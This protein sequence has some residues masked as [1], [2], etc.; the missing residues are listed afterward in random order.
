MTGAARLEASRSGLEASV[1]WRKRGWTVGAV[2]Q[3][4]WRGRWSAFG[5]AEVVW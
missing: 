1:G 2:G 3:T 5:R 4:D